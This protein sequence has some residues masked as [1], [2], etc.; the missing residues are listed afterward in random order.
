MVN[1]E[2]YNPFRLP[3]SCHHDEYGAS[4]FV[5]ALMLK[6]KHLCIFLSSMLLEIVLGLG[7][8]CFETLKAFY[9]LFT[10]YAHKL[11][12]CSCRTIA[13]PYSSSDAFK[14]W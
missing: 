11:D 1:C 3:S 2:V 14:Q 13:L 8:H 6:G 9:A 5:L 4:A 12:K 10:R 7:Y